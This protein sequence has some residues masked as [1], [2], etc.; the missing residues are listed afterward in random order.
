MSILARLEKNKES[1]GAVNDR[2]MQLSFRNRTYPIRF[3]TEA[4]SVNLIED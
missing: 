1:R 3:L 2:R 4:S